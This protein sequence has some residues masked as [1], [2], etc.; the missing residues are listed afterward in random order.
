MIIIEGCDNSG[1]STLAKQLSERLG[2][3]VHHSGGPPKDDNEI[4]SRHDFVVSSLAIR[5][6]IIFDRVPCISDQVYGPIIRGYSPLDEDDMAELNDHLDFP[7]LYCRAPTKIL[8]EVVND[9]ETHGFDTV[10]HLLGVEQNA[11]RI[12]QRYDEMVSMLPHITYDYTGS[13]STVT[14][15]RLVTMI[16]R[17]W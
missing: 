1:K 12:I 10:E 11:L 17:I 5:T 7:I 13:G 8:M 9:H 15:D 6:K 14:I 16:G 3:T 4:R 2:I